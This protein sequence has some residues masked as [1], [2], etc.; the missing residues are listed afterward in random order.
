MLFPKAAMAAALV[1][2]FEII[3]NKTWENT[4]QSN[5]LGSLGIINVV[6]GERS[7]ELGQVLTLEAIPFG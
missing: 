3:G 2:K 7:G 1:A 4:S 5:V 6:P